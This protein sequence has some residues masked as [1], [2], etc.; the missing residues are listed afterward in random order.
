LLGE[1]CGLWVT[2]KE[3]GEEVIRRL[4]GAKKSPFKRERNR[5]PALLT[6]LKEGLTGLQGTKG[7]GGDTRKRGREGDYRNRQEKEK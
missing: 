5:R 3:T 6:D 2:T 7:P 1:A 4:I